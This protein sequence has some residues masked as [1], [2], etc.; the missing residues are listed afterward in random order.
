ML[1]CNNCSSG[2]GILGEYT[3]QNVSKIILFEML[4]DK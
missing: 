3:Y 2:L 4:E 1:C